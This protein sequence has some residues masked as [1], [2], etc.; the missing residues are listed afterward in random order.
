[1]LLQDCYTSSTSELL[2]TLPEHLKIDRTALER[3]CGQIG[4][5][6]NSNPLQLQKS[7]EGQIAL[8]YRTGILPGQDVQLMILFLEAVASI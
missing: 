5:Y 8:S 4:K 3:L 2:Q 1:M 7:L 6:F